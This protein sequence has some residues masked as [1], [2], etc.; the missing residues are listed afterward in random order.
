LVNSFKSFIGRI[1]V[2]KE[3]D[4]IPFIDDYIEIN[5]EVD[6]YLTKFSGLKIGDL[7]ADKSDFYV[8][9]LKVYFFIY[10]LVL[11]HQDQIFD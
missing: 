6:D 2:L 11:L 7:D 1:S 4:Q 3:N 5:Q 10:S 9:N 8:T